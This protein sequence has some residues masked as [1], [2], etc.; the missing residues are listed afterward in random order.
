MCLRMIGQTS[1]IGSVKNH[2]VVEIVDNYDV[3]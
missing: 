1:L 2:E 3:V